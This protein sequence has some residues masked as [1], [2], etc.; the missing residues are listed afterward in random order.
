MDHRPAGQEPDIPG[1]CEKID[2]HG[3]SRERNVF[4]ERRNVELELSLAI[5]N[6]TLTI[7]AVTHDK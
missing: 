6:L 2:V 1:V 3:M 4:T 7:S 5:A